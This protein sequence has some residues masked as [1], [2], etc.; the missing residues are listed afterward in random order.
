M[1]L[2]WTPSALQ[3]LHDAG[4]YVAQNNL[5]SAAEIGQRVLE[6]VEYL[7]QHPALGRA[8]R[9]RGTRELV[10]SGTPFIVVY[11]VQFDMVQVLR[12]MH[13]ARKWP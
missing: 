11:R 1:E 8:G 9:V 6:A 2:S 3:D 12:V 7:G 4:E 5:P 13:H 10:I